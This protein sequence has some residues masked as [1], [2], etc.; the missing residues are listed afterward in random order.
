MHILTALQPFPVALQEQAH[1]Q[2][3]QAQGLSEAL[4]EPLQQ[5]PS[6]QTVWA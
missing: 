4:R 2:E 6:E 3:L 1:W 5:G